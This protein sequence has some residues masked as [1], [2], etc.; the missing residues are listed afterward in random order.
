[1]RQSSESQILCILNDHLIT[2][3]TNEDCNVIDE[4]KVHQLIPKNLSLIVEYI[5]YLH[6]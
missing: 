3:V 1:M 2:I 4:I 5:L 6:R